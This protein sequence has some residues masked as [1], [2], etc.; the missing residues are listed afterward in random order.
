M[1]AVARGQDIVWEPE[2]GESECA[3]ARVARVVEVGVD[4]FGA[5]TGTW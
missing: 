3:P 1:S 5:G 2:T 4:D